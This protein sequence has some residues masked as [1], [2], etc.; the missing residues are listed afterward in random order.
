M[1]GAIKHLIPQPHAHMDGEQRYN[2]GLTWID[3]EG[4]TD[5]H[6]LQIKYIR[7]SE[8]LA[9]TQGE[10]QPDG[11]WKYIESGGMVHTMSSDRVN[12]FFKK[13]QEN[14]VMMSAMIDKITEA[15]ATNTVD[16]EAAAA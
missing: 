4:L 5:H 1:F 10:P 13:T 15:S 16:T 6:N 9:V 2:L 12:A 14:A 11:S 7:N 8:K 3:R